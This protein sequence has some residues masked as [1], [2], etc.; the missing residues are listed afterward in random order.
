MSLPGNFHNEANCH[1]GIFVCAAETVY[2]IKFLAG[3]LVKSQ[4]LASGPSFFARLLVIVRIFRSG[5]PYGIFRFFVQYNEFVFGRTAGIYTGHNVYG[6][7][8]GY[9]AAFKAF[10]AGN[11]FFFE[12]FFVRRVVNHFC[13]VLNAVLFQGCLDVGQ[14]GFFDFFNLAHNVCLKKYCKC[15]FMFGYVGSE[16][17][18]SRCKDSQYFPFYK[19]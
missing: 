11:C 3:K 8:F 5:P 12:K 1:A 19:E 7:Q 2:Y 16:P 15:L 6:A 14:A 9:Y 18:L 4:R 10:E 17:S 13:G